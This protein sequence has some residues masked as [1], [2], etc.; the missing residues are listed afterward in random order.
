MSG[1][2]RT[3]A[4]CREL[5]RRAKEVGMTEKRK[6]AARTARMGGLADLEAS[7]PN[8]LKRDIETLFAAEHSDAIPDNGAAA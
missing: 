4:V 8:E 6:P 1:G 7:D 3:I 5:I 2:D